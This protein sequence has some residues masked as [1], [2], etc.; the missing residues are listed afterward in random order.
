ME[1]F[2]G[3]DLIQNQL[4]VAQIIQNAAIKKV[5]GV[6]LAVGNAVNGA[7]TRNDKIM[8]KQKIN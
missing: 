3:V 2:V 8:K 5:A 4:N 1:N 7:K 6:F